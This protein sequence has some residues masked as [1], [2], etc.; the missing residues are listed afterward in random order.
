MCVVLFFL[1]LRLYSDRW[2][3]RLKLHI[4]HKRESED[5]PMRAA[6]QME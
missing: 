5:G 6:E 3:A 1:R 4:G 2:A